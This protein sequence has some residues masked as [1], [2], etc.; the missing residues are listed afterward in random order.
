MFVSLFVYGLRVLKPRTAVVLR[1]LEPRAGTAR[2][3]ARPLSE[4]PHRTHGEPGHQGAAEGA[5]PVPMG[6]GQMK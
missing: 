4:A 5:A 3:A 1:V 6:A 2:S